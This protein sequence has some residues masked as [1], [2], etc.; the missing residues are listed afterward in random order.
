MHLSC[1]NAH[2][3][4]VF[5]LQTSKGGSGGAGWHVPRHSSGAVLPRGDRFLAGVSS[6]AFQGTNAHALLRQVVADGAGVVESSKLATWSRRRVW[7]APPC[8]PLMQMFSLGA[9]KRGKQQHVLLE[10]RLATPRLAFLQD[11]RIKGMTLAPAAAFLQA[12]AES[13]AMLINRNSLPDCAFVHAVLALPMV[14]SGAQAA[15]RVLCNVNL[16]SGT[17]EI[18]SLQMAD[19]SRQRAHFYAGIARALP[20]EE[21]SPTRRTTTKRLTLKLQ[22]LGEQ[23]EDADHTV[24]GSVASADGA[25]GFLVHP[26]VAEAAVHVCVAH[27]E[28]DN[29]PL[30]VAAKIEAS[31]LGDMHSS[32][33]WAIGLPGQGGRFNEHRLLAGQTIAGTPTSLRG[34]ETRRLVTERPATLQPK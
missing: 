23:S 16:T 19:R 4:T 34:V 6:F 22:L 11:H 26:A 2:V 30:R 28:V 25:T 21:H 29:T 1:I 8:N 24:I 31:L 20:E 9:G 17:V 32:S 10:G 3:Q 7:V 15:R 14:L 13:A 33:T 12:A 27:P 18:G 5:D